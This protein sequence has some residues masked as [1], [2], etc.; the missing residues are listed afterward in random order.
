MAA[1]S[2]NLTDGADRHVRGYTREME[3]IRRGPIFGDF[4][5]ILTEG[6]PRL[7]DYRVQE[8]DSP[9][10]PLLNVMYRVLRESLSED[11]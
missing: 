8:Y 4:V 3:N 2:A 7:Q 6:S 11:S 1:L 10:P 9:L 5:T